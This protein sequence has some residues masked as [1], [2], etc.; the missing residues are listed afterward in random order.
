MK[1]VKSIIDFNGEILNQLNKEFGVVVKNIKDKR[2]DIKARKLIIEIE[3]TPSTDRDLLSLKTVIKKKLCPC[4]AIHSQIALDCIDG[5]VLCKEKLEFPD[6]QTD[7]FGNPVNQ[8]FL[9]IEEE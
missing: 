3:I 5:K 1:E 9:S 6:G 8:K 4:N 7:L 2:T